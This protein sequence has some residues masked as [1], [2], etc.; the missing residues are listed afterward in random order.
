MATLWGR[1]F[2]I[3]NST[4]PGFNST[5]GSSAQYALQST[6]INRYWQVPSNRAV[7]VSSIA[8]DDYYLVFGSSLTAVCGTTNGILLLGGTVESFYVR[9]DQTYVA[10]KSSTDVTVNFTLGYGG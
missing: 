2:Q 3:V 10:I 9:P 1:P 5:S 8:G 6:A 7:R 4:D